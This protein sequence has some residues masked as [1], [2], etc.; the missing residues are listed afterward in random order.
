MRLSSSCL[1]VLL[2]LAPVSAPRAE[3][4]LYRCE[5][6]TTGTSIQSDPCP[7]GSTEVWRRAATPEPT[8]TPEEL[9]AR[10]AA[11]QAEADRIA[12]E[13]RLAEEARQ[14][15]AA[16][17]QAELARQ[18]AA[19]SEPAPTRSECTK[20]HEFNDAALAKP[21]LRLSDAQKLELKNWVIEQCRDPGV[22]VEDVRL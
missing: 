13:A 10:A 15:A 3:A 9:A 19:G 22:P 12:A 20:A 11:A 5:S 17:R 18:A 4:T 16:A 1:L 2:L 7:K 21:W 8:P 6:P 14:A